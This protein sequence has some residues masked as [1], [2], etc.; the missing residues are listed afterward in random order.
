MSSEPPD[1]PLEQAPE[2]DPARALGRPGR[3]RRWVVRPFLWGV[4]LLVALLAGAYFL[5][6][7]QLARGRAASLVVQRLSQYLGRD[8]KVKAVD[9]TVFPL[10]FELEGL[11]IAGP[12]PGDPPVVSVPLVRIQSS[13]RDLRQQ[14]L[15]LEQIDVV[16]PRIYLQFNPDGTSNLPEIKPSTGGRSRFQTRIGRILVQDG[17]IEVNHRRLPLDLDAR[18]VWARA[19]GAGTGE[20]ERLDLLATAQEV[21]TTLPEARPYPLTVSARGSFFLR[22]GRLRLDRARLVGPQAQATAAG[23]LAFREPQRFAVTFDAAGQA[24]VANRLGYLDEPITGPFR[25]AGRFDVTGEDVRFGGRFQ[26]SRIAFLERD[27]SGIDAHLS[28]TPEAMRIDLARVGYAGGTAGGEVDIDLAAEGVPEAAGKPVALDLAFSGL[29]L[30]P[31]IA[32]QELPIEG[33]TGTADGTFRYRFTTSA[34]LAGTGAGDVRLRARQAPSGLP[35]DGRVP[36]ALENGVL[37]IDGARVTAPSQDVAV[38]GSYDLE[39][40][41]GRF[42]VRLDTADLGALTPLLPLE[43]TAEPPAWLPTAGRG[44]VAADLAVAPAGLDA[45]VTLALED[46]AAPGLA[47]DGVRGGFRFRP[48]AIDEL[49]VTAERG[50]GTLAVRGRIPL[51]EDGRVRGGAPLALTADLRSWPAAS[52]AALVPGA[53]PLAGTVTAEANLG[54][55]FDRLNGRALATVE[56]LAVQGNR[57]GRVRADVAFDGAIVRVESATVEMPA[58]TV[59]VQGRLDRAAERLSLVVDAPGLSLAEEPLATYMRGLSGEATLAASFEGPLARPAATLRLAGSGLTL[60]GRPLGE[61][62][63]AEVLATWDGSAVH[64]SGSLL[65][66]LAFEGGGPLDRQGANVAF[67]IG[68]DNL[69]GLARIGLQQAVPEFQGSFDGQLTAR[70]DFAAGTYGAE[71]ALTELVARYE[72]REIRNLEPV[73]V[74]LGPERLQIQSI[75]L[76]EA[77]APAGQETELFLN[78]TIGLGGEQ[79]PLDLRIQSTLAVQWAELFAPA[80]FDLSGN[81]DL[82]A[83]VRGTLAEPVLNGQG[84]LRGARVVVPQFPHSIEEVRG[85]LLFN[86]NLVE[87]ENLRARVGGGRLLASGRFALPQEGQ[88]LDYRLQVIAEDL[89]LRYPEGFLIRGDA[90]IAL[91]ANSAGRQVRGTVDLE[92]AFY[93]EDV[94]L[95]TFQLL[96]RVFQRERLQVEETDEALAATSLNVH[97]RGPGALRVRNNVADLRGDIDLTVRGTLA[98]PVVFGQVEIARGG[99]LVYADNDYE[100]ERGLITFSNPYRIDPVIDLTAHTEVKNFDISLN[101]SGTLEKLN[102]DFTTD[103][104]LAD[105]EVIALLATGQELQEEGTL[106]PGQGG[107]FSAQ[108]FLAGQ[109]ASVVSKRVGKLFG[110]DRFRIS[111]LEGE[112]GSAVSGVGITVGKRISRDLFVTYTS[113]PT[114]P[115]GDL[116]QAEWQVA[117]NVTVVLTAQENN[118]YAVDVQWERRF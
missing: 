39:G 31:L 8:V 112:S 80:G 101:I 43:K 45:R 47:V 14:V 102:V 95:G 90:E 35:L 38:T 117:G 116:L 10:A 52:L 40:Q 96:Q 21:V 24:E 103:S 83:T 111:P 62:G 68:S 54:G 105:L 70:A 46:V 36:L 61:A 5:L 37:R 56:D 87:V 110:F 4:V 81:V 100:I 29:G 11:V 72:G 58:G 7:S 53:P 13:W 97:V 98:R 33:V 73:V 51:P 55:T 27:F 20:G 85:T 99:K 65:G 104:G 64:A 93:L 108:D 60:A 1:K 78:G 79:T 74:G 41:R 84:E 114:A 57:V 75:Y 49:D 66:L 3:L 118:T 50:A 91:V 94:E 69:L 19:V 44:R 109:A 88:P 113:R 48:G 86:R 26:S 71:L 15:Q 82:L 32:D 16:A 22:Q 92:R 17:T 67:D 9:Y 18:A 63:R 28:G 12:R 6:Q 59:L 115:E 42:Q 2:P 106:Q 30:A 89:S 77:G 76:A 107:G 34:P 23:D 25:F